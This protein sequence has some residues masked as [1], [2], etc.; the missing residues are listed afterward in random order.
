MVNEMNE[1]MNE[2]TNKKMNELEYPS[3]QRIIKIIMLTTFLN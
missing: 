2:R 1:W 3:M